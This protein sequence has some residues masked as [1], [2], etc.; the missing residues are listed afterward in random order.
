MAFILD[1]SHSAAPEKPS[2]CSTGAS[3]INK[4]RDDALSGHPYIEHAALELSKVAEL[5]WLRQ[6]SNWL[7]YG[8]ISPASVTDF[9]LFRAEG[10]EY[11]VR[12]EKLPKF[13]EPQTLASI[14]FIGQSLSQVHHRDRPHLSSS[15]DVNLI[16]AHQKILSELQLANIRS[17]A[18]FGS[19]QGSNQAISIEK[20]PPK[21]VAGRG[22]PSFDGS[23]S[24]VPS[25][26]SGRICRVFDSGQPMTSRLG[27]GSLSSMLRQKTRHREWLLSKANSP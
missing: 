4:L 1:P 24:R 25:S 19:S 5:A 7:L 18:A 2:T 6:L 17:E 22:C 14:E 13:V 10:G 21:A 12:R 9:F 16:P 27:A 26:G 3:L 8:Q 15:A 23:P 11:V 20:C